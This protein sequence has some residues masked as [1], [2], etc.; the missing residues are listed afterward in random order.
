MSMNIGLYDIVEF[1]KIYKRVMD[2][3]LRLKHRFLQTLLSVFKDKAFYRITPFLKKKFKNRYVKKNKDKQRD[4]LI[5]LINSNKSDTAKLHQF[6]QMAYLSD[7][8]TILKECKPIYQDSNFSNK[9]YCYKIKF[10]NLKRY[11]AL[12]VKLR[13]NIMHFN[14]NSYR[15]NKKEYLIALSYWEKQ[16]MCTICFMH[17]LPKIK[18]TTRGLL[19]LL[20]NNINN[21][22]KLDDR[23]VCD[24][25]DDLAFLNGKPVDK[26][27]PLW[28]VVRS[29]YELKREEKTKNIIG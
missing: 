27:P 28:S 26:L 13:N 11:A 22:F 4:K 7:I 16:V 25:F 18:P 1:S 3:E 9:F 24:M 21:F 10:N 6:I 29:F 2:L 14:I 17:D 12:L 5:D 23:I 8:M 20:A 19:R 15:Q